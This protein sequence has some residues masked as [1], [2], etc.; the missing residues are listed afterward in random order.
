MDKKYDFDVFN[1]NDYEKNSKKDKINLYN[2]LF[3]LVR[4]RN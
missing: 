3:L 2:Q 1:A 4:P